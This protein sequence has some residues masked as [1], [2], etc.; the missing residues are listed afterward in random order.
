M[1]VI[2]DCRERLLDL[3]RLPLW[4]LRIEILQPRDAGPSV[5]VRRAEQLKDR[6]ECGD[7]GVTCGMS[8]A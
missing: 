1:W 6:E 8:L 4:E 3:L 2:L 7:L 5:L